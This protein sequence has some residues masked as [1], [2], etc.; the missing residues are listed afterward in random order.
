MVF[1][2][3]RRERTWSVTLGVLLIILGII[4]VLAPV[5]AS[6]MFIKLM[7]W[8]LVFAA[9]EQGVHAFQ[10]REEGGLFLKILLVVIY[11]LIGLTLL[12]RPVSGAIAATAIIA[13]LFLLDG[14]TEIRLAFEMR[15]QGRRTQWLF[16]GGIMSLVFAGI[17]FFRFPV[18][19]AWTI[20]VL[21][22][23][24]LIVKG[25]EQITRSRDLELELS[26]RSGARRA[27]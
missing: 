19:A 17:I 25:I 1:T 9:I 10:S 5:I 8:L 15:R 23:S 12:F 21:V 18:S 14:I 16:I 27:A 2:K 4:A 22:G 20:G 13:T 11:G 3:A 6:A 7:G 26:G 24:R